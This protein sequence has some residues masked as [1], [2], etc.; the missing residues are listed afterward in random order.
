MSG[1]AKR[2]LALLTCGVASMLLS[3]TVNAG[4]VDFDP[5]VGTMQ[6]PQTFVFEFDVLDGGIFQ[7]TLTD[8]ESPAPFA[9]LGLGIADEFG[10]LLDEVSGSGPL[11]LNFTVDPGRYLALVGGVPDGDL[12]IGTFGLEISNVPLPPVGFLFMSALTSL[13][14]TMRNRRVV[15]A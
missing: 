12:N 3:I 15:R 7:A 6:G 5:I 14:F 11:A 2:P 9:L 10:T 1:I 4:T 13:V 8:L